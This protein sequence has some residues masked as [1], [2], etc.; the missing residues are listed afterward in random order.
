MHSFNPLYT[1]QLVVTSRDLAIT[2]W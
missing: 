2:L 1:S